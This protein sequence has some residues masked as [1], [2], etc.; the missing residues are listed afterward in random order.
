MLDSLSLGS[1]RGFLMSLYHREG[2]GRKPYPP[3]SILKAQLLKHL[4]RVPS[5]RR[6]ALLRA[7]SFALKS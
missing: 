1:I 6:L 7:R 5:D 2:R 3:V 4:R